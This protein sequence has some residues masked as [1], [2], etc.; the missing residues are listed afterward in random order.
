M[1]VNRVYREFLCK[2]KKTPVVGFY[3]EPSRDLQKHKL[4]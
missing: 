2:R 1:M 3:I 4:K